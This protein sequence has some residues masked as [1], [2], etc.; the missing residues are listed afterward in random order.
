MPLTPAPLQGRSGPAVSRTEA[1]ASR[2]VLSGARSDGL[3]VV[4]RQF[5]A[6]E[7]PACGPGLPPSAWVASL[8]WSVPKEEKPGEVIPAYRQ[9]ASR[10]RDGGHPCR[11]TG[12]LQR[13]NG[14]RDPQ[15]GQC[16]PR[17]GGLHRL[18]QSGRC[19]RLSGSGRKR[20]EPRAR[21]TARGLGRTRA[22][23]RRG[24]YP[25]PSRGWPMDQV[26]WT[27]RPLPP[28]PV[29][30]SECGDEGCAHPSTSR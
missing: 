25:Y 5:D 14:D 27:Q 9:A 26:L 6:P 29:P 20:R 10:H 18:P 19:M 3:P 23:R 7:V 16:L 30:S 24:P 1:W 12:L 2:L 15:A 22:T 28:C 11:G 8:T 17:P 4:A 21:A 13:D